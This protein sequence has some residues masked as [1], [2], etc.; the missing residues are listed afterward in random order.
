MVS[1]FSSK[2]RFDL[3]PVEITLEVVVPVCISIS[4]Y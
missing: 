1:F 2:N 4:Y 3:I